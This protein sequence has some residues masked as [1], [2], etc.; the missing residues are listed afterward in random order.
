[1]TARLRLGFTANNWLFYG[2]GGFAGVHVKAAQSMT[3]TNQSPL[4]NTV[5]PQYG[6]TNNWRPGWAYGGGV[7]WM[8]NPKWTVKA[9]YLHVGTKDNSFFLINPNPVLFT[10]TSVNV[11]SFKMDVARLGLNY[12]F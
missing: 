3:F 11:N 9:E 12:K 8:F 10:V 5:L 2:T 4:G 6:Q 7:E 1:M